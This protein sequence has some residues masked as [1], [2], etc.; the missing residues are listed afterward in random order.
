MLCRADA[1]PTP[2]LHVEGVAGFGNHLGMNL[3]WRFVQ[4]ARQLGVLADKKT[5]TTA[6][7]RLVLATVH[8]RGIAKGRGCRGGHLA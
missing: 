1:F 4:V 2:A 5:C 3:F 8:H 6:S 7:F